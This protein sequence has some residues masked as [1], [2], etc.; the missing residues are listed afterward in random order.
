M[1]VACVALFVALG[2]TALATGYVISSN[3][4]VGPGT[5]SGHNPP[6][7]EHANLAGLSVDSTDLA[8]GAVTARKLAAMSVGPAA[9]INGTLG[10]DDVNATSIQARIAGTCTSG[11]AA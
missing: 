11:Q 9:V 1:V 8:D 5:I 10:A 6:T 2:G 3:G 7:G 4:Q